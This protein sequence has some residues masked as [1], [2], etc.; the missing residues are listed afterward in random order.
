MQN[1]SKLNAF[2]NT[3]CREV[4]DKIATAMGITFEAEWC[5][6]SR[7]AHGS[8]ILEFVFTIPKAQTSGFADLLNGTTNGPGSDNTF[9]PFTEDFLKQQVPGAVTAVEMTRAPGE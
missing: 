7:V 1:E 6:V 5:T 9:V 8:I 3:A 4:A 2:K